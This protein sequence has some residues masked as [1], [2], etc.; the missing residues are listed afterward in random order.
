[1]SSVQAISTD[2]FD[3]VIRALPERVE[4]IIAQTAELVL[5]DA[6]NNLEQKEFDTASLERS[7]S[8][9][10]LA[11]GLGVMFEAAHAPWVEFGRDPG[12][13]PP[14]KKVADWLMEK[15]GIRSRSYALTIASKFC[16]RVEKEGLPPSPFLRPARAKG[17]QHL[18]READRLARELEGDKG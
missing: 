7:G 6:H 17:E 10:S 13:R 1:L 15:K 8:V 5:E 2:R 12:I 18:D 9:E 3:E 11:E 4:E 14:V 16:D